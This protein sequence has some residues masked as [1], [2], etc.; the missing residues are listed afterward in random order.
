MP[1][2]VTLSRSTLA[3]APAAGIARAGWRPAVE[4]AATGLAVSGTLCWLG[5][6]AVAS[7]RPYL[8]FLP[9]WPAIGWLR[10]DTAG[11]IAF[12]V[13]AICLVVSKYLRLSRLSETGSPPIPRATVAIQR[14]A[15]PL[16]AAG[17]GLRLVVAVCETAAI[18]SAAIVVYLSVNAVTHPQT[19]AIRAT[20]FASW[21]TE[22]TL[23]VS[24]LVVVA[25]SVGVLRFIRAKSAAQAS[26]DGPTPGP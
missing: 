11:A 2:K 25:V 13:T 14:Q 3:P 24:G 8:L 9:Y 15:A 6:C 26:T 7:F 22:G 4:A 18:L 5:A 12:V 23:R 10:T 1:D 20:H 19:L 21:P 16:A 17:A